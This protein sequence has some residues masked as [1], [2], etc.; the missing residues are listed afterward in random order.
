ME[1]VAGSAFTDLAWIDLLFLAKGAIG[2]LKI[3]AI[4]ILVGTIVGIILGWMLAAGNIFVRLLVNSLLDVFRS[5]PLIIQLILFDSFVSIVGFP[6]PAFWSG[7]IVLSVYTAALV[8]MVARAG[9]EA[10]DPNLRRAARSLGMGY[11]QDMAYIVWACWHF[12]RYFLH[13]L[14]YRSQY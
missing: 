10:V 3:S 8:A 2:T 4:S 7:T 13:G 12:V 11:W 5:V 9:I 14:A 6:M 1:N